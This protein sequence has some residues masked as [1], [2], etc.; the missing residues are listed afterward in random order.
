MQN[1]QNPLDVPVIRLF[2]HREKYYVYDVY[3][4]RVFEISKEHYQELIKLYRA[5][6]SAYVAD[7]N[8]SVVYNDIILLLQ[9]GYFRTPWIEK[10][11]HPESNYIPAITRRGIS[12]LS[13]QVTNDCNFKCRYCLYTR[14]NKIDRIHENTKMSWDIARQSVDFL[15]QYSKDSSKINIAFY[16]GEPLLNYD[17]IYDVVIYANKKFET[18]KVTYSLTTNGSI[19]SDNIVDFLAEHNFNISISLDG[20]EILQN[21]HRKFYENGNNTF[22]AVW[23]NVNKIRCRQ[24]D[25]FNNHV[26]FHPVIM[27]NEDPDMVLSFF[28]ENSISREKVVLNLANLAGIDYDAADATYLSQ[29]DSIVKSQSNHMFQNAKTRFMKNIHEIGIIP[30]IWHHGGPCV[31]SGK[32]IHVDPKGF[33][34]P[35]EKLISSKDNVIGDIFNGIDVHKVN[36]MLNIGMLTEESCKTCFAMRFCNICVQNCYNAETGHV[37]VSQKE[38]HCRIIRKRTLQHLK[39]YCDEMY[40]HNQCSNE[41]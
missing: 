41:D 25:W 38:L 37:D 18:K 28:T 17:L 33:I 14:E 16:G 2:T 35:C 5:G 4:N 7:T 30:T 1:I 3:S 32:K 23:A 26:Y 6:V 39:E 12:F 21:R 13:L 22:H 36:D 10:I 27:P 24:I 29:A 19:F 20:P 40:S 11:R 31:P 15:W 8:E 9:K 34:Y